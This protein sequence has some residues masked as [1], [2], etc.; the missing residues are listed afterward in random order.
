LIKREKY[1]VVLGAS[2]HQLPLIHVAKKRNLKVLTIDNRPENP[3]HQLADIFYDDISITDHEQLHATLL[4]H[5][6]LGVSSTASDLGARACAYL[7][8][9]LNLPGPSAQGVDILS[10]KDLFRNACR[11]ASIPY[12]SFSRVTKTDQLPEKTVL[13]AVVKPIDRSGSIGVKI[14]Y[15][16]SQ[17]TEAIDQAVIESISGVAII[18]SRLIKIGKQIC[19]DGFVTNGKVEFSHYGDGH[20]PDNES[21]LAPYGETF[22]SSHKQSVLDAL[23]SQ[24]NKLIEIAGYREGPFNVDAIVTRKNEVYIIDI[25]PRLGGNFIPDIINLQTGINLYEHYLDLCLGND[26]TP[27]ANNHEKPGYH[28]SFMVNKISDGKRAG[29]F[30]TGDKIE[31]FIKI[32]RMFDHVCN[33]V[34]SKDGRTISLGNLVM[35]FPD[36]TTMNNIFESMNSF[37]KFK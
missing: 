18:E 5:P 22:P 4:K 30:E 6:P 19:G 11:E 3:G 13:P 14:V 28:A 2:E 29:S 10:K 1:L 27:L 36:S 20:F 9:K 15:N 32:K 33:A 26:L 8:Q 31:K 16:E 12:P 37:I 34:E 17:L 21:A 24:I 7:Q 23:T 35:E 25:G